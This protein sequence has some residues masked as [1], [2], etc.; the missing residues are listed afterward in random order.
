[1]RGVEVCFEVI[2][3]AIVLFPMLL[4][5]GHSAVRTGLCVHALTPRSPLIKRLRTKEEFSVILIEEHQQG[6]SEK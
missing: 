5:H 1:M 3:V 4:Q 6:E 2:R